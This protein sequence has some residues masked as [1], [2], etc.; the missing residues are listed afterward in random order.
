MD[1]DQ[2]LFGDQQAIIERALAELQTKTAA[3]DGAWGLGRADWAVDLPAATIIFT[4][5]T[6]RATAP[7][8][9]VGTY[10][11]QDDSWLWGWEHPSVPPPCALDAQ[12]VKEFAEQHGL[13]R[14][15]TPKMYCTELD[16]WAF[17]ALAAYLAEAQGA[18][19]GPTGQAL[20]FMTF[21]EVT[22]SAP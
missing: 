22:L 8:Q 9:V 4:N 19:R 5:E 18:Y 7:V 3:H 12:K 16:A 15:L 13:G 11:T 2:A 20:V 1:Y 14:L 21:G 10:T 6:F 17:T